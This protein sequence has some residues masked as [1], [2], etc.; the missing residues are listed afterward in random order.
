M[1][2]ERGK[3]SYIRLNV[4]GQMIKKNVFRN[5]LRFLNAGLFAC[6]IL[7]FGMG[8]VATT[9]NSSFPV[10]KKSNASSKAQLDAGT[11]LKLNQNYGHIPLYFEPNEGQTDPQVKFISRG[12]GYTFFI[13]PAEAVFVLKHGGPKDLSQKTGRLGHKFPIPNSSFQIG[14]PDVLRLRLEGGNRMAEFEG[15]EKAE[16]KSNYFIG[17]D[18]S[19]WHTNIA[20]YTKV[21]IK[22]VYPGI[23]MVYYGAQ[24]KLEYDF[25]VKPGADPSVIG[26]SNQ[27]AKNAEVDSQGNLIFHMAQGDVAFKAPIVYQEQGAGKTKI[28]GAYKIRAD[29]KIGFETGNYDKT[30]PLVIDPQL[31]YSTY[32]GGSSSDQGSAIAVDGS[33][34]AYV[35][36]DTYSMDF[37]TSSGAYQTALG[38]TGV[39]NAFISKLNAT[40][41]ALIYSTY[42]GGNGGESG[43]GI[44]VNG[45]GNAYVTGYTT[46]TNFPTTTGAYQTTLGSAG[47]TNAFVTEINS[48]GNALVY[49]TYLGGSESDYGCSIA[50]D[51]TGNAY[52]TG[53]S[54]SNFPTTTGAF[55]TVCSGSAA[56]ITK[57]NPAGN[58]LVYSTYLGGTGGDIGFSIALDGS[59]NAYVTGCTG[60]TD[61]PTSSGA[62]QTTNNSAPGNGNGFITKLN[63]SGTSLIYSTYL[64]GSGG[65][66]ARGIA[67]D[68]T[69][70]V[71]VTGL[72][73]GN[74][75][76]GGPIVNFPTT[77]GA[78]QTVFGGGIFNAFVTKLNSIGSA[79]VY[80]T[81]LGGNLE[82]IGTGIVLDGLGDAYVTGDAESS[83]FPTTSGAYLTA[84]TGNMSFLTELN[85][86]GSNLIYSTLLSGSQWFIEGGV[87]LDAQGNVYVTGYTSSTNYPATDGAYQTTFGGVEDA[88]VVK[89]DASDFY[90]DTPTITSTMT[91]TPTPTNSSTSTETPTVTYS[92]SPTSTATD[93]STATNS[94]T[95]TNTSS[96]TNTPTVTNTFTST[97]SPSPTNTFTI[98]NTPTITYSQTPT[99]T[100]S[101]TPT[102]ANTSTPTSTYTM[103]DTPTP[104]FTPSNTYTTT[105]TG[106]PMETM[107]PTVS[108]T[109]TST[110]LPSCDEFSISKNAFFPSN[111]SVSI[112]VSYCQYP[113]AYFLAIYNS[114]GEHIKTLDAR[115]L[116]GPIATSYFW[117]GRNKYGDPCAS[118]VYILYL[119]EP[120]NRQIKRILLLK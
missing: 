91:T 35:T 96:S 26:L 3:I 69:G 86:T 87:A 75:S 56:F 15:M 36:G 93:T 99:N 88:Y 90:T 6:V 76:V 102:S 100:S 118:G 119:V 79:L 68:G 117:D 60:S 9:H 29:G 57:L 19:K 49:S 104:S 17:N 41:S 94:S 110:S 30:L 37:P 71:Y 24:R 39:S 16:G 27:G 84:K 66:Q 42:L 62:Y 50:V 51:G 53:A 112:I 13:T 70:N 107:T 101:N 105:P 83:N 34:D 47:V 7:V 65:L 82:D 98:T 63:S 106:T 113:G 10:T 18:R 1:Y 67:V 111:G 5:R 77:S 22:E 20:N 59:G 120:Y 11:R 8:L 45:S 81:Y 61:F 14:S 4:D 116:E 38:G 44:A 115:H 109:P 2:I 78:F 58:M 97:S 73:N 55:Q 52:V 23:D 74:F 33:G 40:G 89:L 108:N 28:D 95:V 32:L 12:S 31:D 72:T 46:S 114:A 43:H 85:T 64:G 92:P 80:S 25:E 48:S 54:G 103:T 21:K